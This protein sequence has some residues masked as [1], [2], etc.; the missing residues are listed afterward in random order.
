MRIDAIW[1]VSTNVVCIVP[2]YYMYKNN[3]IEWVLYLMTG[4]VSILYHV[5]RGA[6]PMCA[7]LDYEAIKTV[8]LVM[9]DM[10]MCWIT[11]Y[12]KNA[13]LFL[14]LSIDMY[15]VYV[16][17]ELFRWILYSIWVS[18]AFM[19]IFYNHRKYNMRNFMC[20][21]MCSVGDLTFY[22]FLA[23]KYPLYYNWLHGV[24]H[25]F[26]FMSIYFYT[27]TVS[28]STVNRYEALGECGL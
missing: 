22:K 12:V 13:N 28:V 19:Y 6:T 26:G 9:S 24:H 2:S 8:D 16:R 7:F 11:G 18:P 1:C 4:V 5:H 15:I 23:D 17:N 27:K 10:C 21:V 3:L 25:I 14:F 20:G